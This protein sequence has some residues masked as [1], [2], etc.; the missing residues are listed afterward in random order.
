MLLILALWGMKYDTVSAYNFGWLKG[1]TRSLS[2]YCSRN[3][4]IDLKN[5]LK[6]YYLLGIELH[7]L[8]YK[9]CF[10]SYGWLVILILIKLFVKTCCPYFRTPMLVTANQ[11]HASKQSFIVSS[12]YVSENRCKMAKNQRIF[13]TFSPNFPCKS[14]LKKSFTGRL[15]LGK[16]DFFV[17]NQRVTID[18]DLTLDTWGK[19]KYVPT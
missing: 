17:T 3:W 9:D 6:G 2:I 15:H 4:L 13:Y 5:G 16:N 18:G 19:Y 7:Y 14:T 1:S 12:T 11:H 10:K 8:F